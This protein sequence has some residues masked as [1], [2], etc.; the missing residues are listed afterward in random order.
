MPISTTTTQSHRFIGMPELDDVTLYIE[1]HNHTCRFTFVCFSNAWTS[2]FNDLN[3][4]E[5]PI[6]RLLHIP[7]ESLVRALIW[8]TPEILNRDRSKELIYLRHI[9]QSVKS[10]LTAHIAMQQPLPIPA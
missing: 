6:D 9:V 2:H 8:G 7:V 10:E 5:S 4:H 1:H 3:E